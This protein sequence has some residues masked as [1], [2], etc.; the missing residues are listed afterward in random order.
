MRSNCCLIPVS[1][2]VSVFDGIEQHH[3]L[4]HQQNLVNFDKE[5]R[6]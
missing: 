1:F 5:G 2:H 3:T 6:E 4:Q